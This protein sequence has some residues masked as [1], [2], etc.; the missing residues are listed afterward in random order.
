MSGANIKISDNKDSADSRRMSISGSPQAV[1]TA[2]QLITARYY[3][4]HV[5]SC[6][7]VRSHDPH[8]DTYHIADAN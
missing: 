7:P 2:Q 6:T 4:F 1:R 3:V 8:V 5:Q